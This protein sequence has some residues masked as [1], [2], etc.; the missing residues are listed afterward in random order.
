MFPI[1]ENLVKLP[2]EC[3]MA[4]DSF[5]VDAV[6]REIEDSSLC[7]GVDTYWLRI[8]LPATLE[9][10]DDTLQTWRVALSIGLQRIP[11]PF[12]MTSLIV[13]DE[14]SEDPDMVQLRGLVAFTGFDPFF[15][16]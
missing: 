6:Q 16:G 4:V 9:F 10:S 14:L 2:A 15:V 13:D 8:Q 12:K 3:I 11:V 7:E 1:K 5:L